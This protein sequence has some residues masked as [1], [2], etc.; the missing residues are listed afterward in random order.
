MTNSKF[1]SFYRPALVTTTCLS[2]IV[3]V[4]V[5]SAP[6][7]AD[8]QRK[9]DPEAYYRGTSSM[10]GKTAMLPVGTTFEARIDETIGSSKSRQGEKFTIT[11][12]A[13]I[14]ANGTDVLVPNGA[15]I[16]GEV[17]E[18]IPGRALPTQKG[19]P[20]PTGKLRTQLTSLRTP[21]GVSYPL[22]ASI[23]GETVVMGRGRQ[24][25]NT[26]IGGSVGY[27]G[28]QAGFD[29]V[30]PG[31]AERN[32]MLMSGGRGPQVMTK[33]QLMRDA[34]YGIDMRQQR[35]MQRGHDKIRSLVKRGQDLYIVSGSPVTIRIDAPFKIGLSVSP[36]QASF[37]DPGFTPIEEG[38]RRFSPTKESTPARDFESDP[39]PPPS[40]ATQQQGNAPFAPPANNPFSPP[41][42]NQVPPPAA[43]PIEFPP[44]T[45]GQQSAPGASF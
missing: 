15:Q 43:A 12:S 44:N 14:L 4:F 18:A 27:V 39:T 31:V 2:M 24:M 37:I 42:N 28:T 34:I 16:I 9:T 17:V 20:K 10:S 3:S 29:A 23:V 25:A 35:G 6:L 26:N 21:D 1:T 19:Y 32:R 40:A 11:I 13:P 41:V 38:G 30:A 7:A 36:G 5:V 33:Q 45:G 8:A 22:V